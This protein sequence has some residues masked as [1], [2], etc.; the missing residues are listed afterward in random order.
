MENTGPLEART[1]TATLWHALTLGG[2]VGRRTSLLALASAGVM[3][4]MYLGWSWL[5]TAGLAPIVLSLAPCAAMCA[6]GLCMHRSGP[7]D[8]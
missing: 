8:K 7:K 4:G 6:L 5:V 2:R 1:A 3:A